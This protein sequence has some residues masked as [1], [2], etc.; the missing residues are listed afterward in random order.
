VDDGNYFQYRYAITEIDV[1]IRQAWQQRQSHVDVEIGQLAG[2]TLALILRKHPMTRLILIP[3]ADAQ[4]LRVPLREQ[5][6]VGL[7]Q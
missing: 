2:Q 1:R 6:R 5:P 7:S 4:I 3:D